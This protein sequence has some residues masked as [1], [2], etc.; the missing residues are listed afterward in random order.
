MSVWKQIAFSLVILVAA[1]AAW[2]RF[3]PGA[4]A[5]LS[6]WG[7]EWAAAAVRPEAPPTAAEG[8]G[9]SRR[10]GGGGPITGIVTAAVISATINDNL[11]AI[12]TGRANSS[13]TVTPYASGRVTE[14]AVSPGQMI[15]AGDVIAKLD[16][17]SEEI[18]V[19]RARIAVN[20]ATATLER[21]K[22]LR[23]SNNATGV[24]LTDAEVAL[25]N[26]RLA[27]RDVELALARRTIV[28]PISGVVGILP[29]EIGDQVTTQS[30]IA[31]IDDRSRIIVDFW[32]PERFASAI[33]VGQPL[34][35]F[36]IARPNETFE[37]T[38]SAV[39]NRLDEASRT[40]LVQAALDNG[41]DT[42][43]AGMSFQVSM[44]FPGDSYPAVSPLAVQWGTD[45][46]FVWTV[47]DG[48]AKRTPI[49]IVQRNTETVLVEAPLAAGDLVVV[50]GVH[51]VREGA[52]IM[53]AE[54]NDAGSEQ[55]TS[56]RP[57]GS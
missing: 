31:T 17:D 30:A 55:T 56:T 42:L 10:Q 51:A 15:K 14:I 40:L 18:A 46:A 22:A 1:A 23:G 44:K 12:G 26:A 6:R 19:D 20:N 11:T 13:V 4:D 37:G 2:A 28:S 50:E 8:S 54:R 41:K 48:R 35:A 32:V 29:A 38:V 39:D 33:E 7:I 27:L 57:A 16:S 25:D 21:V 34:R 52:E 49:R 53:V 43:R 24:Q 5:I 9:D 3:F 45:G 47:T 36:P